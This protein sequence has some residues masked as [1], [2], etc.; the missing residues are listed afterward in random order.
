VAVAFS[1]LCA[2]L[3]GVLSLRAPGLGFIMITLA[4]GQIVWGVAYRANNLTGG[5]NGLRLPARPMPFGIDIRD[6]QSFYYFTLVVFAVALFCIWRFSRSPFCA[7]LRG[8]RD[9]PRRMRMLGHNVWLVQWLTFVL[10]G[11]WASIAG[12][13][14]V[15]YNVFLSP[16]ALGLQ[17]D[18]EILLMAI[19]G[20]ASSLTGPIVGA[21]I[22][23][24]VKNV[25]S[26]YVERW[27]T[28]LG[29][30]FVIVI[31]FM[32]YG[33]VPGCRQ[34][35]AR[36]RRWRAARPRHTASEAAE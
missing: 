31:L 10:A 18:A 19:L 17:Q 21:A 9:Q 35:W 32:P 28:L 5:D 34:L 14:F 27:N 25:V 26:T 30:I 33:L 11:F 23:T 22:I 15:Y 8:A 20:G 29:A 2:A 36:L 12:L 3:F 16:H 1:T 24:L 7:C 4:L 6:A 13:L